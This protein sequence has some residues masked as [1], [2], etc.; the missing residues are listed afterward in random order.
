MRTVQTVCGPVLPSELGHFQ[1]HE[2][3]FV[4]EGPGTRRF[5][6]LLADDCDLSAQEAAHYVSQGGGGL[7]DAQPVG[8]GRNAAMLR[9][10]SRASGAKI[11]CVT[12]YHLPHFYPQDHWIHSEDGEALF[13]RFRDELQ[14][15]CVECREV[16]PGAVKAALGKEGLDARAE[17]K[18]RAAA[19]AAA[20]ADVPIVIHTEK[21][22]GGVEAVQLCRAA[23]LAPV[24]ILICHV[25]RQA[26]DFAPHDAIADTGAMLEYDTIGRFKYHDD[27]S[28]I[29]LIRHMIEGGHLN[30]LL[31]SLDTTNQR[32]H[33]YGG[34]IGLDYILNSFL[35]ALRDAGVSEEQLRTM[36]IENPRQ[37]FA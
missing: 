1:M 20:E 23:G 28:E 36:T 27:A 31:L 3:L 4:A 15:G 30:Q 11:V 34:E 12:G 21:G 33:A 9:D 17:V 2:H 6:A 16:L 13:A 25:D 24:R 10:I 14:N 37:A 7:L 18:L 26:D 19:R 22:A 8:A 35:P 5:P 29:R 32:L